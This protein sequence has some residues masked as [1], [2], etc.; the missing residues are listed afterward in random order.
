MNLAI[1]DG[2]SILYIY[3]CPSPV[4]VTDIDLYLCIDIDCFNLLALICIRPSGRCR[5]L[6]YNRQFPSDLS[7]RSIDRQFRGPAGRPAG[8]CYSCLQSIILPSSH[9]KPTYY[10]MYVTYSI[11]TN[12]Y[13]AEVF[14]LVSGYTLVDTKSFFLDPL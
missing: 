10:Y 1:S 4:R 2:G 7:C 14:L 5:P 9:K 12:L 13:V 8:R 11:T 3:I 6:C